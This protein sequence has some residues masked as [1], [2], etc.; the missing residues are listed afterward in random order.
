MKTN[1]LSFVLFLAGT[2][3]GLSQTQAQVRFVSTSE[4]NWNNPAIWEV[5]GVA[6]TQRYP[7][8]SK[9]SSDEI[10]VIGS[11]VKLTQNY[12]VTGKAGMLTITENGSLTEDQAGRKLD[13]GS[14]SGPDQLRLVTNGPLTVSS[15]NFYKADA[16]I[17]APLEAAC[18]IMLANQS[19]LN[20]ESRVSIEGNLVLMQGNNSITNESGTVEGTGELAIEGCVM[21][22]G[23]GAG[24]VKGLF[25][26]GLKVCIKGQSSDCGIA[27]L[28]NMDC[29]SYALEA[30]TV[31]GCAG[32]LPVQ[33][34]SFDGR[35]QGNRVQ[36]NWS[37]AAELQSASF[38]VQRSADGKSFEDVAT[39]RAAGTSTSVRNYTATDASP[40]QGVNYY[41]LRQTDLDGTTA[42]SQ[43]VPVEVSSARLAQQA[44]SVYGNQSVMNID[45]Q[46]GGV[47][48]SIR[49]MDNMGRVLRTEQ[50]PAGTT[51]AFSRQVTL[52]QQAPGGVY[53]VQAFTSEGT[54]SQRVLLRNE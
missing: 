23:N 25:D 19:T 12:A 52:G 47:C 17:N 9:S 39:V 36:L 8:D 30:I 43:V 44:M 49:I 24:L 40:R 5:D 34:V 13:F 41:R 7:G 38:T 21:T 29:N 51:G 53:I 16:D 27:E 20:V 37:T 48:Q 26:A 50:L 6:G 22:R 14:Q 18:S 2:L 15:L 45:M 28:Q 35:L 4:G 31:N 1:I 46:I 11:A 3:G 54:V 33:L 32:P 10:V 42:Y